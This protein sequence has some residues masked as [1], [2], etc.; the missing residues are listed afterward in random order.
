MVEQG[1]M[2]LADGQAE[3]RNFCTLPDEKKDDAEEDE[4]KW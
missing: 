1:W 3:K 4:E 2:G